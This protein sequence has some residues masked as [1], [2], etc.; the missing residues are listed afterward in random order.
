[1]T[2]SIQRGGRD[3]YLGTES[4]V[5]LKLVTV[6]WHARWCLE[7]SRFEVRQKLFGNRKFVN[8]DI[9]TEIAGIN[10]GPHSMGVTAAA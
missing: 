1:M 7:N 6:S 10:P 2:R 8:P 5:V 3:V 9:L 4:M